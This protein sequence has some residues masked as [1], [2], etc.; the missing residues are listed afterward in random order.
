MKTTS[1]EQELPV[2]LDRPEVRLIVIATCLCVLFASFQIPGDA[3]PES[4]GPPIPLA[5]E[6][7][8]NSAGVVEL[9]ML[10][11]IGPTT[12]QRIIEERETNGPYHE[13]IDLLRVRGIGAKTL[14]AFHQHLRFAAK[15]PD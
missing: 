13:D 14:A 7:D 3:S 12:A 9:S 4:M 10:P 2:T 5:L 11:K 1:C 15:E 6:I 8:P